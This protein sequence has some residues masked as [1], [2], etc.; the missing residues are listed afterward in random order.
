MNNE[1]KCIS[2]KYYDVGNCKL[3]GK[4]KDNCEHWDDGEII[5]GRGGVLDQSP[6][7]TSYA[8]QT[9]KKEQFFHFP[10]KPHN[11]RIKKC[12]NCKYLLKSDKCKL[13][14]FQ[15]TPDDGCNRFEYIEDFKEDYYT[16]TPDMI[17]FNE[18]PKQ[19][20][21]TYNPTGINP[22][23]HTTHNYDDLRKDG[24]KE[25]PICTFYKGG[26]C[27]H[28]LSSNFGNKVNSSNTCFWYLGKGNDFEKRPRED[29]NTSN[30]SGLT[31]TVLG[32]KI[33]KAVEP[34]TVSDTSNPIN[35]RNL[36]GTPG[37]KGIQPKRAPVTRGLRASSDEIKWGSIGSRDLNIPNE[38]T[39]RDEYHLK[40][41]PKQKG[42][43][44]IAPEERED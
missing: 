32:K 5:Q 4:L 21:P 19:E 14:N 35:T 33:R 31:T 42:F 36:G 25:C 24:A 29:L 37:S 12:K 43:M 9:E 13:N 23:I 6:K 34:Q 17:G 39:K 10:I 20:V 7:N 41:G 15:V 27:G 30:G 2:C 11:P 1:Q 26:T 22:S 8:I 18:A 3:I 40:K 16:E 44:V 38:E 28:L